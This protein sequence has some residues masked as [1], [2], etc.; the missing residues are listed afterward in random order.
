MLLSALRENIIKGFRDGSSVKIDCCMVLRTGVQI[1]AHISQ[2]R[3]PEHLCNTSSER[4]VETK[5]P[6]GLAGFQSSPETS[7]PQSWED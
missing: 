1:P 4:E 2:A 7:A 6:L 5:G 3:Y